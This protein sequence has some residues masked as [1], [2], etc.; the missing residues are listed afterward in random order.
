M[1]VTLYLRKFLAT[2]TAIMSGSSSSNSSSSA[3][4]LMVAQALLLIT[5]LASGFQLQPPI[6]DALAARSCHGDNTISRWGLRNI[7]TPSGVSAVAGPTR[8]RT[9]AVGASEGDNFAEDRRYRRKPRGDR[10]KRDE[11]GMPSEKVY[12]PRPSA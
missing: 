12:A 4:W 6:H 7:P 9:A 3:S 8:K 11:Y 5:S 1:A 2:T 10:L